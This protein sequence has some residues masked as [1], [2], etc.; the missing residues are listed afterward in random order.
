MT[1]RLKIRN[2]FKKSLLTTTRQGMRQCDGKHEIPD[3]E[4]MATMEA[5]LHAVS[6]IQR[7]LSNL[8]S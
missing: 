5:D 3:D 1:F 2:H 4:N 8:M 6:N 7:L